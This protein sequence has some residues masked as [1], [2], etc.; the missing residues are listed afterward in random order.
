MKPIRSAG[1]MDDAARLNLLKEAE[2]MGILNIDVMNGRLSPE[3]I[4]TAIEAKTQ[5]DSRLDKDVIAQKLREADGI[6]AARYR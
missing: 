2:K 3:V 1:I 4:K 6:V 5:L